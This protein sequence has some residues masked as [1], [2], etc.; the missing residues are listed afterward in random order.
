[1]PSLS[2]EDRAAV[3]AAADAYVAAMKAADW[4]RVARSFL[5]D[6]VRIPPNEE[7]HHGREAIEQWLGGIEE[8][9]NYELVRDQIDGADGMAYV[10]GRYAITLRPVGAPAPIADEGDFLEIW[11]RGREGAWSIAEA[12]WNTRL[13]MPA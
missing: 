3:E 11:R 10:R 2:A 12:M 6:A 7:P 8:I 9:G 4:G 13:P 5:E 1:M